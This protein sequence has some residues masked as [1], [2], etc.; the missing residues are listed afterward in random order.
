M[1]TKEGGRGRQKERVRKEL[2]KW[3]RKGRKEVV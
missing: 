3:L 1:D 2:E